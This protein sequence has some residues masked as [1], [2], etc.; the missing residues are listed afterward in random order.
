MLG[1]V[2]VGL[3]PSAPWHAAHTWSTICLAFATSGVALVPAGPSCPS[4]MGTRKE[5]RKSAAV[6]AASSNLHFT[7]FVLPSLGSAVRDRYA[8]IRPKA[9]APPDSTQSDPR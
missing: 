8:L 5:H 2:G 7:F 3:L 1:F 4:T 6:V 9:A